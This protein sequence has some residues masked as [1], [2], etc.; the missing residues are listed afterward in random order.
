[1]AKKSSF[2]RL[3]KQSD[4]EKDNSSDY[5]SSRSDRKKKFAQINKFPTNNNLVFFNDNA[6]QGSQVVIPRPIEEIKKKPN[7]TRFD[8]MN[9]SQGSLCFN[10]DL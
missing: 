8:S 5:K 4:G 10:N 3:Q 2:F 9:W 1:M 7:P 6:S